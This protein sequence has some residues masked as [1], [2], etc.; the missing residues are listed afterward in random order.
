M[1]VQII[2]YSVSLVS[3]VIALI[4]ALYRYFVA[5]FEIADRE[6]VSIIPTVL[7]HQY[8]IDVNI[9]LSAPRRD[10]AAS[11]AAF[12]DEVEDE[13]ENEFTIE[14]LEEVFVRS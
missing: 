1:N 3:C 7:K 13:D 8:A 10:V 2:A 9:S 12:L 5:K 11:I 14:D 6:S 4:S